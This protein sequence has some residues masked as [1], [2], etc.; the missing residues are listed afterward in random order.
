MIPEWRAVFKPSPSKSARAAGPP[1]TPRASSSMRHPDAHELQSALRDALGRGAGTVLAT[2]SERGAPATAFC[3]WV[4][5]ADEDGL[6]LALDARSTAHRNVRAGRTQVALE[7]LA[8]DMI[9]AV[10][11]TAQVVKEQ[12][13]SV[14][15]PCSLVVVHVDE[16]R[17]HGVD[18]VV[19]TAP[20]YLF[21]D[22]KEHRSEVERA[23]FEELQQVRGSSSSTQD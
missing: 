23:I 17:D 11:G 9:L 8:D 22:G 4:V 16:I 10:R 3:S 6:A 13:R 5:S 7:I 2:V 19:F 14:P 12:M 20:R 15:F 18:G 21:A 1:S